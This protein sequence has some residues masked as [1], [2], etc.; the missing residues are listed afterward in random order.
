MVNYVSFR[1]TT[2][3]ATLSQHAEEFRYNV[4]PRSLMNE[5]KI[6]NTTAFLWV[7]SAEGLCIYEKSY[8]TLYSFSFKIV[9]FYMNV[10]A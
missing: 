8:L 9:F 1:D 10:Y 2:A 4:L 3:F 7:G 5:I 6:L